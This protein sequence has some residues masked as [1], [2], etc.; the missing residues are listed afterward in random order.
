[1]GIALSSPEK[2]DAHRLS[3]LYKDRGITEENISDLQVG[4]LHQLSKENVRNT[5]ESKKSTAD[6]KIK[7]VLTLGKLNE[8]SGAGG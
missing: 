1:M 8:L 4:R 3:V 2:S 7:A 6:E 5:I